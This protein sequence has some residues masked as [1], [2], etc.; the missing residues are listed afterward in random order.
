[1]PVSS[2]NQLSNRPVIIAHRGASGLYPEN[3]L[4]A[5]QTAHKDGADLIEI[6]VRLTRDG[7]VV[8]L[9]DATLERTTNGAGKVSWSTLAE[10]KKLDA[11][12]R[13]TRDNGRSYPFA[14]KGIQ[15]PLLAEALAFLPD[16]MFQVEFKDNN[17]ALAAKALDV[18]KTHGALH[19]TQVATASSRIGRFVRAIEPE[20][21]IAHTAV[22]TLKFVLFAGLG[23]AYS[24]CF[25][26][27]FIDLPVWLFCTSAMVSRAIRFAAIHS[28]RIRAYTVNDLDRIKQLANMGV[29]GFF[30][31]YPGQARQLLDTL[32][33]DRAQ[34]G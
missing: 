15:V 7:H 9:H 20:V 33:Q 23:L 19:R 6:D 25:H 4:L 16:S 13:F 30:T 17:F 12:M 8:L 5:L 21:V 24:P 28:L 10:V 11:G 22:D 2:R 18:I 3:T 32:F 27:G 1:M 34:T 26:A 29:E 14:R 31:D